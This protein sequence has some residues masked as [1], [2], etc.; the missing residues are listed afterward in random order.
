[1]TT[2]KRAQYR[3]VVKEGPEHM[4]EVREGVLEPISDPFITAEPYGMEPVHERPLMSPDFL[5]FD[6][7]PGTSLDEAER[8]ADFLNSHVQ[9][10][11][12]TRFGDAEDAARDVNFSDRVRQ[13]DFE[14]LSAA[15]SDLKETLACQSMQGAL[16]SL[17]AVE[18]ICA[19]VIRGWSKALSMSQEILNK[20]GK[21]ED[22]IA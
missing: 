6:L 22:P 13:I 12:I 4:C 7:G 3:F 15:V 11:A 1:M 5:S 9:Y 19:D 10:V 8:I 16:G 2:T 21:G 17:E 18:S 14:R 20:F